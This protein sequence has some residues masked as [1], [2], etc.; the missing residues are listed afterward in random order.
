LIT[1]IVSKLEEGVKIF[2]S[3]RDV[4]QDRKYTHIIDEQ[5]KAAPSILILLG[6]A[7]W[8]PTQRRIVLDAQKLGKNILFGLIGDP[9]EDAY[10]QANEMIG[11]VEQFDFRNIDGEQYVKIA[12]T[13][14][15]YAEILPEGAPQETIT[16]QPGRP[17]SII[18]ALLNGDETQVYETPQYIEK[19]KSLDRSQLS[20]RIL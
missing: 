18:N 1:G 3:R 17:E 12:R 20:A 2:F 16:S 4:P 5:F 7:G 6:N 15:S 14:I 9:P 13:S 8:G 19:S 10:S 11:N